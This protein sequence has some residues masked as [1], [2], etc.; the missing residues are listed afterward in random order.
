MTSM[1]TCDK[2]ERGL[3][4]AL[5]LMVGWVFLWAAIHHFGDANYVHAF[6][7]NTKTFHFIYG[8]L[9]DSS[10]YP[11]LSF[12]VE[13]GHLLIGLSLISGLMVRASAP[14]AMLIMALYWTA[15]MNFPYIDSPLNFLVDEHTIMFAVL[16]YLIVRRAGHVMGLDGVVANWSGVQHNGSLRWLTA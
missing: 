4:V 3:I 10:F 8:P 9:A 5:R 7:S 6:L 12:L 13:Y 2:A 14:F 15:H 11:V 16:G 1:Y